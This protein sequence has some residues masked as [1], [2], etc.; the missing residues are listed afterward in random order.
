MQQPVRKV[1]GRSPTM[2]KRLAHL[3]DLT[4]FLKQHAH[5]ALTR[6][7]GNYFPVRKT[8]GRPRVIAMREILSREQR[9]S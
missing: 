3:E 6:A 9:K 8:V 5:G 2:S 4:R 7:E 1:V